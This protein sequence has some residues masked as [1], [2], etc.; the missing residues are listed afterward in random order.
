MAWLQSA[1]TGDAGPALV[2]SV[3][4]GAALAA[5]LEEASEQLVLI[6]GPCASCLFPC[7]SSAL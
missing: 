5:P 1:R 4:L 3:L 7:F 2:L 6:H